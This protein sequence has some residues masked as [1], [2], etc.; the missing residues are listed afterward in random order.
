MDDQVPLQQIFDRFNWLLCRVS[1][2]SEAFAYLSGNDTAVVICGRDLPDG[3]WKLVLNRIDSLPAPPFLIVTSRLANDGFWAE[4]LNLG[5]YDVLVQPFD[6][7]EVHR[8]VLMAWEA[9]QRRI[10]A[11]AR[12]FIG[13]GN[14]RA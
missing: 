7:H 14:M 5:G 9:R 4:V 2:C 13:S 10:A 3:D 11:P 6:P 1:T 12:R 8:I